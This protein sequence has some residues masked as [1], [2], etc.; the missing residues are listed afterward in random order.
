MEQELAKHIMPLRNNGDPLVSIKLEE[1]KKE[2]HSKV[3]LYNGIERFEIIQTIGKGAFGEVKLAK[4]LKTSEL[5]AL[6]FIISTDRAY[7]Q[8][9]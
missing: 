1:S 4:D 7:S 8:A 5:I 3:E 2:L 6:K 9:K